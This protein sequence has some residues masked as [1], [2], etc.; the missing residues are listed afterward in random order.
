MSKKIHFT[1]G[2]INEICNKLD[3]DTAPITVDATADVTAANGNA[4]IG[5]KKA[6]DRAKQ[7]L[8]NKDANL[9][10][11]ADAVME[12]YTKKQLK[13]AKLRYLKE[14]SDS[15]SKKDFKSKFINQ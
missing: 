6:K 8:G 4:G 1:E 9:T 3:E 2:Q 15:Y 12:S 11:D 14:H 7:T 5:L 13:E 10:C